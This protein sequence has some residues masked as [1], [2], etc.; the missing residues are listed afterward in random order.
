MPLP[1]PSPVIEQPAVLTASNARLFGSLR[2]CPCSVQTEPARK[3]QAPLPVLGGSGAL[4]HLQVVAT[5]ADLT[6]RSRAVRSMAVAANAAAA[7]ATRTNVHHGD[8]VVTTTD[9][10]AGFGWTGMVPWIPPGGRIGIAD[11]V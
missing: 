6:L 4:R 10:G 9:V 11:A 7:A 1:G 3:R 2:E 5:R 8:P